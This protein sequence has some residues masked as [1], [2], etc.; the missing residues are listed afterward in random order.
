MS[1]HFLLAKNQDNHHIISI[2]DEVYQSDCVEKLPRLLFSSIFTGT[3]PILITLIQLR[4]P[5]GAHDDSPRAPTRE[6]ILNMG[7]LGQRR[8]RQN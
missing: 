4:A 7:E 8:P 5:W 3:S 2:G 1:T 6:L